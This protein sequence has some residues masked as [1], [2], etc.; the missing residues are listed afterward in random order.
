M[1]MRKM[2][3]LYNYPAAGVQ[4]VGTARRDVSRKNSD[5]M[6]TGMR[7]SLPHLLIFLPLLL[8]ALTL[9]LICAALHYLNARN[10]LL[11]KQTASY[12]GFPRTRLNRLKNSMLV[13]QI[14]INSEN[15]V[16][17]STTILN[18]FYSVYIHLSKC[19]PQSHCRSHCPPLFCFY[20][21]CRTFISPAALTELLDTAPVL[22][23]VVFL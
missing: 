7:V 22:I 5:G 11:H 3:A 15:Y 14:A 6:G 1:G 10:R 9:L 20:R 13:L 18:S 21:M 16:T 2:C 4:I 8:C 12:T 23:K 17:T 19:P